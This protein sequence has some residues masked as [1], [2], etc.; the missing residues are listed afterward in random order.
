MTMRNKDVIH[1]LLCSTCQ[2][3]TQVINFFIFFGQVYPGHYYLI[4][5]KIVQLTHHLSCKAFV[6][7]RIIAVFDMEIFNAFK[8]FLTLL[9]ACRFQ[10][11]NHMSNLHV[12]ISGITDPNPIS[13]LVLN[14]TQNLL[15]QSHI[16]RG[17]EPSIEHNIISHSGSMSH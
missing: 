12:F 5:H 4:P 10:T 15:S 13:T 1:N 2:Q 14:Q 6:Y 17:S 11:P 9:F 8:L 16:Y 7:Y 3:Q